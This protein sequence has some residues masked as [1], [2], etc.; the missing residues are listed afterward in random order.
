M[1]II[2]A[3]SYERKCTFNNFVKHNSK[4]MLK[5]NIYYFTNIKIVN[6]FFNFFLSIVFIKK[7]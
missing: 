3:N 5:R 6:G 7:N 4:L 1:K 2:N